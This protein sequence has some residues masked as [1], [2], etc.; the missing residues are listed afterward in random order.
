MLGG[1]WLCSEDDFREFM[2]AQAEAQLA[3]KSRG[4][5][6]AELEAAGLL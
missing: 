6:D 2:R 5:S 4:V 1:Q 3:P